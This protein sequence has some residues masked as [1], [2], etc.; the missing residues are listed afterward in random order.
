MKMKS[1][2][3]MALFAVSLLAACNNTPALPTIAPTIAGPTQPVA[4]VTAN[5]TATT[6]PSPVAPVRRTLP[7]EWTATIPPT[8]TVPTPTAV[9]ISPTPFIPQADLPD[10]CNTFDVLYDQ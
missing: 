7:P 9:V 5:V 8:A 6:T 4:S 2:F 1:S 10:A 3:A